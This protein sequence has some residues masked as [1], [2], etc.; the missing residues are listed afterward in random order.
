[1][2]SSLER[3]KRRAVGD[4]LVMSQFLV[5][6]L[7]LLVFNKI[8]V[9]TDGVVCSQSFIHLVHAPSGEPV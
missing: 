6:E 8:R 1:M 7:L 3:I 9:Q 4:T 5:S 2:S